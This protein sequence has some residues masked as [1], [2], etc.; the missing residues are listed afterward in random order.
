MYQRACSE[1]L[2]DWAL[3]VFG[4]GT[5]AY[6]STEPR[7]LENAAPPAPRQNTGGWSRSPF[8]GGTVEHG[9]YGGRA[10]FGKGCSGLLKQLIWVLNGW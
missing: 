7:E 9:A 2:F 4:S 3:P 1:G 8:P 6:C 10:L 5:V